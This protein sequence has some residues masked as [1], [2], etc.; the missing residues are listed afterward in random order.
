[1]PD[2]SIFAD[3][4]F[5]ANFSKEEILSA[6]WGNKV[7][8]FIPLHRNCL[9]KNKKVRKELGQ[10]VRDD[11]L[12]ELQ[13]RHD[14]MEDRVEGQA[15]FN[16]GIFDQYYVIP[17]AQHVQR[18]ETQ[19]EQVKELL[20]SSKAFSASGQWNLSCSSRIGNAGV[21]LEAQKRQLELNEQA[22]L[23][24]ESKKNHWK[25]QCR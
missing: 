19:I 12:E 8:F 5:D 6:W 17:T 25:K 21:T 20:M 16:V 23:A 18:A 14:M 15:S 9:L 2:N 3:R 1:M 11:R 10:H 4:P 13:A 7:G 24:T 22:R